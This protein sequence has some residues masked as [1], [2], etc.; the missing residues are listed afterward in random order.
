MRP[1]PLFLFVFIKANL[2]K[3]IIATII[4]V[5]CVGG[6]ATFYLNKIRNEALKD[7]LGPLSDKYEVKEFRRDEI[8]IFGRSSF[9]WH[10]KSKGDRLELPKDIHASNDV[11]NF[12][13]AIQSI[14]DILKIRLSSAEYSQMFIKSIGERQNDTAYI[15]IKPGGTDIYIYLFRP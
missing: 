4:L 15:L 5:L 7:I 10:L 8:L 6:G 9:V 11:S 12:Q 2:K 1:D 14:S 13:F 3:F